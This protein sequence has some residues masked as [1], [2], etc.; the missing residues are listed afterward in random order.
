MVGTLIIKK[1]ITNAA[2]EKKA[3]GAKILNIL[4]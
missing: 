1:V 2:V 4:S 3:K